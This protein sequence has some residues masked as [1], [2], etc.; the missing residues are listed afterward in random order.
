MCLNLP[1]IIENSAAIFLELTSLA[2]GRENF[3]KGG[4]WVA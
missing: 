2:D 4:C 3:S 1:Q